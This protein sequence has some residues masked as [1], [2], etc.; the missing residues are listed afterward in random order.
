MATLPTPEEKARTILKIFAHFGSKPGHV[1]LP[2]NLVAY[3]ANNRIEIKDIGEGLQE[4]KDRGWIEESTNG[5]KL[6]DAGFS[7]M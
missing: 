6:T 4:A 1:L 2:N 3:G 5:V 7:E